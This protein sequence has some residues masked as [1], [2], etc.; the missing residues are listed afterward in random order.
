MKNRLILSGLLATGLT[1]CSAAAFA[2][3][4]NLP[5]QRPMLLP[6]QVMAKC[7]MAP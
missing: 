5:Q 7:A 6:R 2:Q 3:Q 4:D 1:L